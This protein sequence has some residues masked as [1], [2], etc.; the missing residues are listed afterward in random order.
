[1]SD[2]SCPK[3]SSSSTT[4]IL[5][6]LCLLGIVTTFPF[7]PSNFSRMGSFIGNSK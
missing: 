1:M 4:K 3:S 5:A 2:R 6:F 7:S